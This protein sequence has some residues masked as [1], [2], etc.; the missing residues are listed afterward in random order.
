MKRFF[1]HMS[2]NI[3]VNGGK[4]ELFYA[5]L[6]RHACMCV[7]LKKVKIGR[8]EARVVTVKRIFGLMLRKPSLF[9]IS[10]TSGEVYIIMPLF[11]L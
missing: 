11:C 10:K 9:E 6:F 2:K 4:K 5:P 3:K 7:S 1:V 8:G